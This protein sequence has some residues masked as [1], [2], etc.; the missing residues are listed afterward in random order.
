MRV[1]FD[2]GSGH[3]LLPHKA[4][5][6]KACKVHRSYSP[7]YSHTSVH[8]DYQGNK[9]S[10]RAPGMDLGWTFAD[11]G[12][13]EATAAFVRDRVCLV[14]QNGSKACATTVIAGATSMT[15]TPF[16]ALPSD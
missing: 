3:V 16:M 1:L 5:K 11:L 13:G 15:D 14:V 12:S 8:V 7:A 9:T 10:K 4:C 2:T 6:S